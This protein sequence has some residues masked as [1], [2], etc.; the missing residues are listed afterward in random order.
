MLPSLLARDIQQGLKQFLVAGF[1]PADAFTWAD[2]PVCGEGIGVAE[3]ESD[4]LALTGDNKICM[5]SAGTRYVR[6]FALIADS[7]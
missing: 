3:R 1:E 6:W 2:E 4:Q 7:Q 5:L